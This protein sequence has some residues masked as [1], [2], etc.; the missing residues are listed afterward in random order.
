MRAFSL[1]SIAAL[2]VAASAAHA[3][4]A[5][6]VTDTTVQAL[7]RF[8]SATPGN[9]TTI[10]NIAGLGVGEVI[11]GVDFR[12]A[13]GLL[14]AVTTSAAATNGHL[15]SINLATGAA[16][17][18]GSGF[19]LTGNTSARLSVDFN[20]VVD[21]LRVV[22]GSGQN[23]RVNPNDGALVAQDTS[24]D[25]SLLISG[26]AYSNNVAGATLTTLY[27][28]DYIRDNVGTIGGLNGT[29]SPNLG[30]FTVIGNSGIVSFNAASGMDISG[31]TGTA[32][33]MADDD[34]S[35]DA[36][37]EFYRVNL[38]TGVVTLLGTL[39]V[40]A[41]DFSVVTVP[42]PEPGTWALMLGGVGLL[43]AYARRRQS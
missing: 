22:T 20:P 12:P 33:F 25:P 34:N 15:Y 36:N 41:I 23:Y 32:F 24:L 19:T 37:S 38:G 40:V 29:P 5:Y 8:D 10:N 31:S 2:T 9:V 1:L 39:T 13:N 42:V 18:I 30:A 21:R 16:T 3:E 4:L 6:G 14:Y 11:R 17:A 35:I 43:G 7:F 26:V 28:Y 27:G